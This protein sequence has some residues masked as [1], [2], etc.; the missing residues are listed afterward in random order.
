MTET[1]ASVVVCLFFLGGEKSQQLPKELSYLRAK[2]PKALPVDV[3]ET[4]TSAYYG[5]L[6]GPTCCRVSHQKT[7]KGNKGNYNY[8]TNQLT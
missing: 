7:G 5:D 1:G 8:V 2:M 6:V 3:D 4:L